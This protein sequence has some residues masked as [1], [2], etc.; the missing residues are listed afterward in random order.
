MALWAKVCLLDGEPLQQVKSVYD[1]KFFPI[2]FRHYFAD[3][4]ESEDWDAINPDD[5]AHFQM[6]KCKFSNFFSLNNTIQVKFCNVIPLSLSLEFFNIGYCGLNC[7][8]NPLGC[9]LV[10]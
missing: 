9:I 8:V 6:A 4:I 10:E 5:Q 3:I 2:E 7:N 1:T